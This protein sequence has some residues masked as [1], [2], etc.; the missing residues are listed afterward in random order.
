M[1]WQFGRKTHAVCEA[2]KLYAVIN[3]GS[4]FARLQ[5]FVEKYSIQIRSQ[6]LKGSVSPFTK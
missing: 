5:N 1:F 3:R 4:P 2:I 6:S